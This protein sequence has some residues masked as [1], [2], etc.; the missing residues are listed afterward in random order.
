[1]TWLCSASV[2]HIPAGPCKMGCKDSAC[3]LHVIFTFFNMLAQTSTYSEPLSP[4]SCRMFCNSACNI[5][6]GYTLPTPMEFGSR[7]VVCVGTILTTSSTR[8]VIGVTFIT[9]YTKAEQQSGPAGN[10]SSV[11]EFH[12]LVLPQSARKLYSTHPS[13]LGTLQ[14]FPDSR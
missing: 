10:L 14:H 12:A 6:H 5:L 2:L 9:A 1:M 11:A 13:S 7:C 3:V 8:A 4:G